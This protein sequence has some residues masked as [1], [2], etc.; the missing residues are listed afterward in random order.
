M[1]EAVQAIERWRGISS[2]GSRVKQHSAL[3]TAFLLEPWIVDLV[4]TSTM[5]VE[6][7]KSHSCKTSGAKTSVE[8]GE[9][10]ICT[11][12]KVSSEEE[13]AQSGEGEDCTCK[14][15][16]IRMQALEVFKTKAS[17][18]EEVNKKV[19]EKHQSQVLAWNNEKERLLNLMSDLEMKA[20]AK[21]EEVQVLQ[22][23]LSMADCAVDQLTKIRVSLQDELFKMQ[24]EMT[25]THDKLTELEHA[26]VVLQKSK[27]E[28]IGSISAA[29][30]AKSIVLDKAQASLAD[31]ERIIHDLS[32]RLSS[33]QDVQQQYASM[34]QECSS[35]TN[36]LQTLSE[37]HESLKNHLQA[38]MEGHDR[39]I[40]CINH[41]LQEGL[42]S[43][44]SKDLK[45]EAMVNEVHRLQLALNNVKGIKNK[46][47]LQSSELEKDLQTAKE[48]VYN[49][50]ISLEKA[51]GEV[52]AL[53]EA[54]K[55]NDA[56]IENHRIQKIDNEKAQ[57][58]TIESLQ[59]ELEKCKSAERE[60]LLALEKEQRTVATLEDLREK[61]L[62][63]AKHHESCWKD[64]REKMVVELSDMHDLIELKRVHE[65]E[66]VGKLLRAD[67]AIREAME[68][69]TAL[70]GEVSELEEQLQ[71]M[72]MQL[73]E[74]ESAFESLNKSK[75]DEL[76]F[77]STILDARMMDL[78]TSRRE[79][80]QHQKTI[81]ALSDDVMMSQELYEKVTSLEKALKVKE[82]ELH[83]LS[84]SQE[85][86]KLQLKALQEEY[87]R[88][89]NDLVIHLEKAL[90]CKARTEKR[91]EECEIKLGCLHM[92]L[93][94]S[95]QS[96]A[97]VETESKALQETLARLQEENC[98]LKHDLQV[99]EE[100]TR[101][102]TESLKE[103]VSRRENDRKDLKQQIGD[104][105]VKLSHA[106]QQ[107]EK[108]QDEALK[109]E[110]LKGELKQKCHLHTELLELHQKEASHWSEKESN[111]VREMEGLVTRAQ[112]AEEK[113]RMTEGQLQTALSDLHC[114][115]ANYADCKQNMATC[116]EQ[117]AQLHSKLDESNMQL[118]SKEQ[119]FQNLQNKFNVTFSSLSESLKVQDAAHSEAKTKIERL[120][121]DAQL[122]STE[123]VACLNQI[124]ALK[125]EKNLYEAKIRELED[126][127]VHQKESLLKKAEE[128]S[129]ITETKEAVEA[130]LLDSRGELEL[131]KR[132]SDVQVET[133]KDK[134]SALELRLHLTLESIQEKD[135]EKEALL[136]SIEVKEKTIEE[137]R[138]LSKSLVEEK[139]ML[140]QSANALHAKTQMLTI[141]MENEKSA[142]KDL[143]NCVEEKDRTIASLSNELE[144]LQH[145][146]DL[147]KLDSEKVMKYKEKLTCLEGEL[148]ET[149]VLLHD[150]EERLSA[151][152]WAVQQLANEVAKAKSSLA[153]KERDEVLLQSRLSDMETRSKARER[154]LVELDRYVQ[155][156]LIKNSNKQTEV[157]RLTQAVGKLESKADE[158]NAKWQKLTSEMQQMGISLEAKSSELAHLEEQLKQSRTKETMMEDAIQCLKSQLASQ[159]HL[160]NERESEMRQL[161]DELETSHTKE[162]LMV[163]SLNEA[164]TKLQQAD[165][166]FK[167][168]TEKINKVSK[169]AQEKLSCLLLKNS[170]LEGE[171]LTA[172][173]AI[174]KQKGK[175]CTLSEMAA[176]REVSLKE[177][178]CKFDTLQ[179]EWAKQMKLTNES[180]EE[181]TCTKAQLVSYNDK[182][183]RLNEKI[184]LLNEEMETQKKT[185]TNQLASLT[186]KVC[187]KDNELQQ[188]KVVEETM[189]T[190]SAESKALNDE[191]I[192]LRKEAEMCSVSIEGR[193][194]EILRLKEVVKGLETEIVELREDRL[195]KE[196]DFE[197]T[198]ARLESVEQKCSDVEGKLRVLEGELANVS[199]QLRLQIEETNSLV[200][201]NSALKEELVVKENML[202]AIN[203]QSKC[204]LDI[205]KNQL[206]DHSRREASMQ[207]QV[208]VLLQK[209][210]EVLD[211]SK[212]QEVDSFQPLAPEV[213]YSLMRTSLDG[214]AKTDLCQR[215]L[216]SLNESSQQLLL[217]P[218]NLE[219][220]ELAEM[221]RHLQLMV[222]ELETEEQRRWKIEANGFEMARSVQGLRIE[223]EALKKRED[224]WENWIKEAL[225]AQLELENELGA[226]NTLIHSTV[227]SSW[228]LSSIQTSDSFQGMNQLSDRWKSVV[229]VFKENTLSVVRLLK[230]E[231]AISG[232]KVDA[233]DEAST[234]AGCWPQE[235]QRELIQLKQMIKSLVQEKGQQDMTVANLQSSL[236]EK[237]EKE[238][239][240]RE[241]V[242]SLQ[243]LLMNSH[244][245][246]NED[247]ETN[248][249][250]STPIVNLHMDMEGTNS[251]LGEACLQED[252]LSMSELE[253]A[254]LLAEKLNKD[255]KS[256]LEVNRTE[257]SRLRQEAE[258]ARN[259]NNSLSEQVVELTNSFV[260]KEQCMGG[261]LLYLRD[262]VKSIEEE[263]KVLRLQ[264]KQASEFTSYLECRVDKEKEELATKLTVANKQIEG[265]NLKRGLLEKEQVSMQMDNDKWKESATLA[266][267]EK[268]ALLTELR[269]ASQSSA[270]VIK[271][272]EAEK[273]DLRVELCLWKE[274]AE[275]QIKDND[276]LK[277]QLDSY[278]QSVE[279]LQERLK[280]AENGNEHLLS[281]C[282]KL[283]A[284]L[285]SAQDAS[286]QRENLLGDALNEIQQSSR[287][288]RL[289]A[290]SRLKVLYE[291]MTHEEDD[292]YTFSSLK[293]G[294]LSSEMDGTFLH[295]AVADDIRSSKGA[296]LS[297]P[298]LANSQRLGGP[299]S[300][301]DPQLDLDHYLELCDSLI[302]RHAQ[303]E[304][305]LDNLETSN[306]LGKDEQRTVEDAGVADASENKKKRA[307]T[308]QDVGKSEVKDETRKPLQPIVPVSSQTVKASTPS[309]CAKRR[310]SY[311]SFQDQ[312]CIQ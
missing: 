312:N 187:S 87:H 284:E 66:L 97:V 82:E 278:V 126:T 1:Y 145:L 67:D 168:E 124:D 225:R 101:R 246:L 281:T 230:E 148:A 237:V 208:I 179:Q 77:L 176:D 264:L 306:T 271:H 238:R 33:L 223:L 182:M 155:S 76:L 131:A 29:L 146:L 6:A 191:V 107:E 251:A 156:L 41:K 232:H 252:D 85:G 59:Q 262:T 47:E 111:W 26:S 172:M 151:S 236:Q 94:E 149:S 298:F 277:S 301:K 202:K 214:Y 84:S 105:E 263:A 299:D 165:Q 89:S 169:E 257:L 216:D 300:I 61:E 25:L 209:M 197:S 229:N 274:R 307:L 9:S 38:V 22:E 28:G 267:N 63:S 138:I 43:H 129:G 37:S 288:K 235:L 141:V 108:W 21:D 206:D 255:V 54:L 112:N 273:Q 116:Q 44:A 18:L 8:G 7:E 183:M 56:L 215:E 170:D 15:Q 106:M 260:E 137:L 2:A 14:C 136:A 203:I 241:L 36:D 92:A 81:T 51:V 31:K 287:R 3:K 102:E 198:F 256:K 233:T 162:V 161:L 196:K 194:A 210:R 12:T 139:E 115:S 240:A 166:K 130:S 249:H 103:S 193:D 79:V 13:D 55:A 152:E 127:V 227:K 83:A 32:A 282:Q 309:P 122:Q 305:A 60:L 199:M 295:R 114:L 188:L 259:L 265:L 303:L 261:E 100:R 279:D 23:R 243:V 293:T 80:E 226:L 153:Q 160:S 167:E 50:Q 34:R 163:G 120:E 42:D 98:S 5:D 39:E 213:L 40:D 48:A 285:I 68:S 207:A 310:R 222:Q 27:E 119:E 175:I 250:P 302:R 173:E 45:M 19:I 20:L 96:K 211:L 30:H 297:S 150:T 35:K 78:E 117:I 142:S 311:D 88:D 220:L 95:T 52:A 239:G 74:R 272:L 248:Q 268:L 224:T 184:C 189:L 286:Q 164:E 90:E 308:A 58:K 247:D 10:V 201:S 99:Q 109:C 205:V 11:I 190:V 245:A 154:E 86:S 147:S 159:V 181:L 217:L 276:L 65:Q 53:R 174:E 212:Q 132:E 290:E 16:Q 195:K 186:A 17:S 289:T 231:V 69:R 57:Q 143:C 228:A 204:E 125:K 93:H 283:K 291:A 118:H 75:K 192:K 110:A 113:F 177:L 70:Q 46:A 134:M 275:L 292:Q 304:K 128:I 144:N 242:S 4:E 104:M 62:T 24:S 270:E 72:Q 244:R 158:W 73:R 180:N 64:E 133:L 258:R 294:G 185:L 140:N 135:K 178:N 296:A 219:E 121:L 269:R 254:I 200:T 49:N 123:L 171:L 91:L 221:I 71:K 157:E 253:K 234:S 280:A 218:A 266:H